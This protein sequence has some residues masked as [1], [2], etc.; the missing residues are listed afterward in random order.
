MP[1]HNVKMSTGIIALIVIL[2]LYPFRSR[3]QSQEKI[4]SALMLNFAR[5]IQWP[6]AKTPANFI[7]GVLEYPPLA[8]ELSAATS[9]VKIGNRKIEVREFVRPEEIGPCHILFIPAYKARTLPDVL[10]KLAM[11]PTLII[12]NKMDYAKK[13]SGVNFVLIEGRL[14]YEI[15][16]RSIEERGMKISTNVKGMGIIVE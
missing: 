14:R 1:I 10:S 7:M 4:Y 9:A 13:G 6:D 12:T 3:A 16:C 15:N 5:G 8:A 11:R 2:M